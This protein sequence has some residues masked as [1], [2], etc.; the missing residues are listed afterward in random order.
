MPVART[1]EGANE[2]LGEQTVYVRSYG[3]WEIALL[4][5]KALAGA[6]DCRENDSME[7]QY[8]K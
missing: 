4:H 2:A 5:A 8:D 3:G 7:Q 1:V 6:V